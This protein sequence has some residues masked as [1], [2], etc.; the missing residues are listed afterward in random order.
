MQGDADK[1]RLR[2]VVLTLEEEVGCAAHW[3]ADCERYAVERA[4]FWMSGASSAPSASSG[5]DA[6]D[7]AP[8]QQGAEVPG[9]SGYV[10]LGGVPVPSRGAQRGPTDARQF[11]RT[12]TVEQNLQACALV[13]CQRRP[14]LLE[15]PPGVPRL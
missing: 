10:S 6:A 13:L 3:R 12:P 11:V 9:G 2:G 5:A 14:L 8:A 1:A 4:G 15:G 7:A